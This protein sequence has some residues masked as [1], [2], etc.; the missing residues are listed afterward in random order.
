[1][2]R[3]WT[4]SFM[5]V[6]VGLFPTACDSD[7]GTPDAGGVDTPEAM[8]PAEGACLHAANGPATAVTAVAFG[9]AS[10]PDVS[11][12][13][14]RYDITLVPGDGG[15]GADAAYAADEATDFVFFLGRDVPHAFLDAGGE[16]VV[17][18]HTEPVDACT[19][20]A[21]H[22][23]VEL[24]IGT[25]RLRIGPTEADTVS[26]VVEEAAGHVHE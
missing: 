21:V 20:L 14:T 8:T 11:S 15:M 25:I 24:G 2:K 26:L 3:F 19:E 5:L 18:E 7:S 16:P 13:H 4:I 6:A 17:P 9:E 23:L 12:G 1:M 22:S 10:P